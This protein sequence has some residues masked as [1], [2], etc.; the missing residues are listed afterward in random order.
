MGMF[1]FIFGWGCFPYNSDI[2]KFYQIYTALYFIMSEW[3]SNL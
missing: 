3:C 2:D 1:M